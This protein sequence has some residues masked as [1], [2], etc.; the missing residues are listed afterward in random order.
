MSRPEHIA[1]PEIVRQHGANGADRQFYNAAEAQKYTANTRVQSI[2]AE[3]TYRCLELL[4]LCAP[5]RVPG[6]RVDKTADRPQRKTRTCR[7]LRTCLTLA[8]VRD[9]RERF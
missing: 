4:D 9:S 5:L 7:A 6:R 8:L 1:P 2:Q 3:M